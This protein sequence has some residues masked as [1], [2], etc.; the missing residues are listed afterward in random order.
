VPFSAESENGGKPVLAAWLKSRRELETVNTS[1]KV[2]GATLSGGFSSFN[3][4]N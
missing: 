3:S 1:R 4:T 2:V